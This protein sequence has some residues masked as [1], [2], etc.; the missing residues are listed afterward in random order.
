MGLRQLTARRPATALMLIAALPLANAAVYAW[1]S[2]NLVVTRDQWFLLPMLQDYF[3][4]HFHP[5]SLWLT[6]SQHRIPAYKLL[7]LLDAV[8]LKLDMRVEIL[9]GAAALALAVL[10][11]MRR[12]RDTSPAGTAPWQVFLGLGGIALLGFSLNQWASLV[13][14]LGALNGFGRVASFVCF[15]LALDS[16]LRKGATPRVTLALCGL[17]LFVLFGWA[18]GHGPAYIA[19]TLAPVLVA[20]KL[21]AGHGPRVGKLLGWVML[22]ALAAEAVYWLA[23]PLAQIHGSAR[24]LLQAMIRAPWQAVEYAFMA[25]SSSALPIEGM[26]NH[27]FPHAL[28]LVC[29]VFIAVVYAAAIAGFIRARLWRASYLPAFLM[30]YA[31]LVIASMFLARFVKEGLENATAPRYVLDTQLGLVGC[32]WT[33]FLWRSSKPPVVSSVFERMTAIPVMFGAVLFLEASIAGMI[34]QH[35][36]YQRELFRQAVEQVH[37]EDFGQPNWVC[38]DAALCRAGTEFL[39]RQRLNIFK[40][41]TDGS[42]P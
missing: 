35:N 39:K 13:Y 30:G 31:L 20:L 17:L 1:V 9:L 5:V 25:F 32:Y 4:G 34:W 29:G 18:G 22:T 41:E 3:D 8:F 11:L 42:G 19:A 12:F 38:P 40:A 37:A 16:V 10:L 27:G 33:L 15:W 14:G 2:A 7:F 36:A 21:D 23:G 28:S 24:D 26:E 6:H